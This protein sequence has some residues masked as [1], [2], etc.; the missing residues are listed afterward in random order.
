MTEQKESTGAQSFTYDSSAV[1]SD[2][3]KGRVTVLNYGDTGTGKTF[4]L[5]TLPPSM[6]PALMF[7]IDGNSRSLR[8]VFTANQ[9]YIA[10]FPRTVTKGRKEVPVQFRM[11]KELVQAAHKGEFPSAG[12][13][14]KTV[15]VDTLTTF[16]RAVALDV[17]GNSNKDYAEDGVTLPQYGAIQRGIEDFLDR[18]RFDTTF[19]VILNAHEMIIEDEVGGSLKGVPAVTGKQL[20]IC[21]PRYFQEIYRSKVAGRGENRA[22]VWSTINEGRF[23]G[24]T[25]IP[26]AKPEIPQNYGQL[27]T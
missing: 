13:R 27:Q 16:W 21:V 22:Y 19:N 25:Q 1:E 5:R 9:F 26:N 17:L 12:P 6:L 10:Q 18:L 8:N 4:S 2:P 3:Y 15:I 11:M 23:V 7:D 24:R 14:I 20:P